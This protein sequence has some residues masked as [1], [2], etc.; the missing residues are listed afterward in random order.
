VLCSCVIIGSAL[1]WLKVEYK[2]ESEGVAIGTVDVGVYYNSTIVTD[3][4]PII[5]SGGNTVRN[6][7]LTIK[8][9]GTIDALSRL[10]IR[11]YYIESAD[12]GLHNNYNN[13]IIGNPENNVNFVSFDSDKNGSNEGL[14]ATTWLTRFPGDVVVAGEMFC[15][16]RV[17]PYVINGVDTPIN[18]LNVITTFRVSE[19]LKNT[20]VYISITVDSCA[21][22]GNIYKKIYNNETSADDIPVEAYPFGAYENLPSNWLTWR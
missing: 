17:E 22:A 9:T 16:Q 6:L 7:N 10:T 15:N 8:N 18:E 21:Y 14:S 5:I 20:D 1:A 19:A 12:G 11:M 3:N 4:N 13:L 2:K